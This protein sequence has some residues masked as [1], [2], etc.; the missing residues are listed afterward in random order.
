MSSP[1]IL[2]F[3]LLKNYLFQVI[4]NKPAYLDEP[5]FCFTSDVDWA[6]ED[7]LQIQ[8][9]IYDRY[10]I[11]TT[12]F[13]THKSPLL[14]RWHKEGKIQLGIHPNFLP[15][16]SHGNTIDE[17]LDTVMKFAPRARCFRSHRCF[18][19]APVT[20]ALV[21]RGLLYDSNLITNLQQG[22]S[23]LKH[24]SGLIRFP[25]FYEDGIHFKWRRRWD[26]REFEKIFNQPGLK[27]I[28]HHPM[29]TA[30]NVTTAEKWGILKTKFPPGVWIK[31]SKEQLL[32]N[33]CREPGPKNFLEDMIKFVLENK[34]S[35]MSM[36]ELY[37]N[38]GKTII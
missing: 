28:S 23:P 35:I 22:I 30:M 14:E 3:N 1:K 2:D 12:Y 13:V 26:F 29:I 24:E 38:F 25:C 11:Q 37:Q 32:E 27:I 15:G 10:G 8:Q 9:D 6:S 7:A 31:M 18:D 21:K 34:F 17:V 5:I 36:E 4:M 33:A 20:D 19:V 16:S